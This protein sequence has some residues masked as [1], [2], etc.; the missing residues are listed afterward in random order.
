MAFGQTQPV[1]FNY[2]LAQKYALLKQQADAGTVS[3]NATSQNA[4]TNAIV[5]AASAGL[6]RTRT[7]LLP[8][9][10]RST[11][12][13][14]GAQRNLLTEQAAVVRPE[15]T[16]RIGQ[17]N[18]ETGLVRANTT[19]VDQLNEIQGIQPG[20]LSNVLGARGYAGPRLGV[21][22]GGMLPP[23][24]APRRLPGESAAEYM[25]RT[26]WGA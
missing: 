8:A 16:A 13:L 7:T 9:E 17:M 1:D 18:A 24:S 11:I 12:G 3:A 2:F 26:G 14:Q 19:S 4:A 5:G 10:S 6:D 23:T 20:A 21:L 25:D 15:S 22:D